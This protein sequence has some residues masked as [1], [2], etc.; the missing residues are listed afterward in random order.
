MWR[1]ELHKEDKQKELKTEVRLAAQEQNT[2]FATN[3]W[4]IDRTSLLV[5]CALLCFF[6]W[7]LKKK[8][9]ILRLIADI[10]LSAVVAEPPVECRCPIRR[11]EGWLTCFQGHGCYDVQWHDN[12]AEWKARQYVIWALVNRTHLLWTSNW[13]VSAKRFWNVAM[14]AYFKTDWLKIKLFSWTSQPRPRKIQPRIIPILKTNMK[15]I[16]M[17]LFCIKGWQH[18]VHLSCYL[19][20]N[21]ASNEGIGNWAIAPWVTG[22]PK[23][24][25]F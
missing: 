14:V 25:P 1:P 4:G 9:K 8:K 13:R 6:D 7:L 11:T 24:I 3:I 17:H 22:I 2:G 12:T 18:R 15:Y 20:A 5:S 10:I 19:Q 16:E 23:V 21:S